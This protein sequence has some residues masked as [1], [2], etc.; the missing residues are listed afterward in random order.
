MPW[1]VFFKSK[2]TRVKIVFFFYF[3]STVVFPL[4]IITNIRTGD[5][6]NK[7]YVQLSTRSSKIS[8]FSAKNV[9][10]HQILKPILGKV[11]LFYKENMK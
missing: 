6:N 4:V 8:N 10:E 9:N 11:S 2:F 3:S 7:V 1:D 5:K